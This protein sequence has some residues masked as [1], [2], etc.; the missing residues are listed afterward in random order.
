MQHLCYRILDPEQLVAVGPLCERLRQIDGVTDVY[1]D[2]PTSCLRLDVEKPAAVRMVARLIRA[3]GLVARRQKRQSL[4]LEVPELRNPEVERQCRAL[5]TQISG[6]LSVAPH[7]AAKRMQVAINETLS[8]RKLI[9][10]LSAIGITA[11]P[12]RPNVA[13]SRWRMP[14]T[15]LLAM[16]V[17]LALAAQTFMPE[18][19]WVPW[20]YLGVASAV[21]LQL[22]LAESYRLVLS[23][24]LRS[25]SLWLIPLGLCVYEGLWD[26]ASLLALAH[27]FLDW[28]LARNGLRLVSM[29]SLFSARLPRVAQRVVEEGTRAVLAPQ[30]RAGDIVRVM[31][32]EYVPADG[33]ILKGRARL[34]AMPWEELTQVHPVDPGDYL[35][36]GSLVDQGEF[37]M[38]LTSDSETSTMVWAD[39]RLRQAL[40]RVPEGWRLAMTAHYVLK[41]L[42]MIAGLAGLSWSVSAGQVGT[43]VMAP[44]LAALVLVTGRYY[45]REMFLGIGEGLRE[46]ASL[47]VIIEDSRLLGRLGRSRQVI[48]N[49]AGVLTSNEPEV[50]DVVALADA[51]VR[52]LLI[53]A[54]SLARHAPGDYARAVCQRAEL[55]QAEPT[56]AEDIEVFDE[57]G[58]S[59]RIGGRR[60]TLG[61][62]ELLPES[63]EQT[64]LR[65]RLGRW[66]EEGANAWVL[67]DDK[68]VLA[69]LT[70]KDP[71][72]L[73][74][75]DTLAA[76][77]AQK[78]DLLAFASLDNPG[79]TEALR[80][81]F[82]FDRSLDQQTPDRLSQWLQELG[83][84][85][86][87][88]W[89]VGGTAPP[90]PLI[91]VM[92]G[93]LVRREARDSDI[94]L[95][96]QELGAL[97]GLPLVGR[98]FQRWL[99]GTLL[100][101]SAYR[102]GFLSL[103]VLGLLPWWWLAV[104]ELVFVLWLDAWHQ[105]RFRD[106]GKSAPRRQEETLKSPIQLVS[107]KR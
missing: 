105:L 26:L 104:S 37:R 8:P 70:L 107:L 35:A 19:E 78:I 30:L 3:E 24:R 63:V 87:L 45:R 28:R 52:E 41:S 20:V 83:S 74:V 33:V 100:S 51:S 36:A 81:R 79:P 40:T 15:L 67:S 56:T 85:S 64:E 14:W 31:A 101:D 5:P 32:G 80:E 82:G 86:R 17:M 44:F 4:T 98:K 9:C 93:G 43:E 6:V 47:G 89:W 27:L 53:L 13:L 22:I 99:W 21:M 102:L 75:E 18:Q 95:L 97:G 65:R 7:M 16:A 103:A 34:A 84:Q 71:L 57:L 68:S 1:V 77:R 25:Q 90:A 91:H 23:W 58:V 60:Y 88:S 39:Q 73:S 42:L 55:A 54:G 96:D 76:L 92:N 49:K 10:E 46:L 94:T 72:R 59:A 38:R 48:F 62:L 50:E 106:K 11:R 29:L 69:L 61:A 2:Y 66:E 12:A